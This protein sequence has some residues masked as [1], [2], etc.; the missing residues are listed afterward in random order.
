MIMRSLYLVRVAV[1][2]LCLFPVASITHAAE[3]RNGTC[4]AISSVPKQIETIKLADNVP[5]KMVWIPAGTFLMGR[6]ANEQDTYHDEAP[7]HQVIVSQ[8]FWMGKYAVTKA[9]WKA[10]MGTEPWAG[11]KFVCPDAKSPAVYISWEAAQTFIAKLNATTGKVFRLPTESEWEYACRAGTTTRFYWGDDP[12]CTDIDRYGWWRGNV[13]IS[14]KQFA[15]PVGH[16]R[17]NAWG[18][19]DMSG[20][21]FQWCQDWYGVYPNGPVTDPTG[22]VS[23][24]LRVQRGGS[25]HRVAGTCRSAR[26]GRETPDTALPESGLRLVMER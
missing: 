8:G 5:L 22:A 23:G 21:V 9:Q 20:N 14:K 2:A 24:T 19:F 12:E 3:K 18:L 16:K 13:V 1:L 6:Y 26:R 17:P 11:K 25:W 15:R 10:V 7:Q 4:N